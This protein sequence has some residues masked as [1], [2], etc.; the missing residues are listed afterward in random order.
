MKETANDLAD[1]S[2]AALSDIGMKAKDSLSTAGTWLGQTLRENPLAIGA[3]AIAAGT[4]VGLALPSTRI[5]SEYVGETSEK[6][7]DKAQEVARDAIHRVQSAAQ[8]MGAE[9]EPRP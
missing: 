5:E 7:V 8:Q 9:G 1:R 4:A 3:V 2:T 6:L